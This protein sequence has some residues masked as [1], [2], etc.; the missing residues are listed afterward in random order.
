MFLPIKWQAGGCR[1]FSSGEFDWL[2][3]VQNRFYNI[4]CKI[5]QTQNAGKIGRAHI[6]RSRHLFK[7]LISVLENVVL[8]DIGLGQDANETFIW[9][10]PYLSICRRI[11]DQLL[12]DAGASQS[13]GYGEC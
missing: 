6:F 9:L 1:K 3:A 13:S 10:L 5:G 7:R 12:F 8:V 2:G 4:W 11:D